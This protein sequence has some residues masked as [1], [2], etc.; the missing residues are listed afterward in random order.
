MTTYT[1][2]NIL[3][4]TEWAEEDRPR[5]KLMTIGKQNL[6]DAELIAILLNSGSREETAV[7]LAKR[8]LLS[9]EKNL[10][11]L[12]KQSLE[13]LQKFKGIGEAKAITIAA[14]ME[15]GRR[16]QFVNMNDRPKIGSSYDSYRLLAPKLMDLPHEEFWILALDRGLKVKS[17]RLVSKGGYHA[18]V[19]D[20]KMVFREA[21]QGEAS[22]LI[23]CHN[24]PSGNCFPSEEDL[25]ITKKIQEAAKFLEMQIL[26]HVII[27]GNDYYSFA[28]EGVL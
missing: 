28:D 19:V 8:L 2:Q 18:T 4:I 24:H 6:S 7:S 17:V 27:A 9:V 13:Q 22:C 3:P 26:D 1:P 16:R 11:N 10:D 21:M 23:L 20:V 25:R 12:G 15:L 5:E 14:A